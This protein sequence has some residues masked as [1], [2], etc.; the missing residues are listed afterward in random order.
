MRAGL[1]FDFADKIELLQQL[2]VQFC[3]AHHS[4][5]GEDA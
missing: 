2:A 1:V 4:H 5:H 3:T